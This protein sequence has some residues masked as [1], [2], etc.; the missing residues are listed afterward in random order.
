MN[1]SPRHVPAKIIAVPDIPYTLTM[2]KVELSV[3]KVI[4]RQAVQNKDALK[5]PEA[6]DF[7]AGIKEL[8]EE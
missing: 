2:K 1:T 4:E 5:N 6:L 3:K 8:L 7:Y